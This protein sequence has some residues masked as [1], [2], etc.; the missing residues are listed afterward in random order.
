MYKL[1]ATRL[2]S[3]VYW[4]KWDSNQIFLTD[5]DQNLEPRNYVW[6]DASSILDSQIVVFQIKFY[7]E[8]IGVITF[9]KY[10]WLTFFF[11]QLF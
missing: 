5:T 11:H 9:K 2:L 1:N 3:I 8:T 7:N 6:V 4:D 10:S